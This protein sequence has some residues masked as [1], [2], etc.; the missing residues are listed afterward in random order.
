MPECLCIGPPRLAQRRHEQIDTD[1]LKGD[2]VAKRALLQEVEHR[3]RPREQPS[4][5]LAS[6]DRCRERQLQ[7]FKSM[8]QAPR[9][10]PAHAF[11]SG[12]C[13]ARRHLMTARRYPAARARACKTWTQETCA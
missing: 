8:R 9:F 4:G 6:A 3:E 12:H 7:R 2:R 1:K 10:L 5:D 11:I 13:R